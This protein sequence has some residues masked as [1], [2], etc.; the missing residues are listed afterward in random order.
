MEIGVSV[1][2]KLVKILG[3]V[4]GN[5]ICK[6]MILTYFFSNLSDIALK[7]ASIKKKSTENSN[8][9]K[10]EIKKFDL[11]FKIMTIS[12]F[13]NEISEEK[14][15]SQS[16]YIHL[17]GIYEILEI[18]KDELTKLNNE[19]EYMQTSWYYYTI[20]WVYFYSNVNLQIMRENIILL[21]KRYD[22]FLKILNIKYNSVM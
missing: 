1:Q 16:V 6:K 4:I 14:Y 13:L 9:I 15:K 18:I 2:Y 7:I 10:D 12:T 3:S 11:E 8:I 17:C 5:D 22:D 20:G 21:D 19:Y